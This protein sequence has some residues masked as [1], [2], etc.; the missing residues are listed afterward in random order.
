MLDP[1]G[2]NVCAESEHGRQRHDETSN[3]D[4]AESA[5]SAHQFEMVHDRRLHDDRRVLNDDLYAQIPQE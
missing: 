4:L 3:D 1:T 2:A 5:G